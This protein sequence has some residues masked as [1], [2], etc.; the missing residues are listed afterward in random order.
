MFYEFLDCF[1]LSAE[2]AYVFLNV[3]V[4]ISHPIM[5]VYSIRALGSYLFDGIYASTD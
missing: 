3:S 4:D 5:I 2:V 1:L